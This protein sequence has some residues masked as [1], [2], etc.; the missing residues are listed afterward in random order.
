MEP[1][2]NLKDEL[3]WIAIRMAISD[4]SL[5]TDILILH[6]QCTALSVCSV[7]LGMKVFL[8]CGIISTGIAGAI[9]S[10]II[11]RDMYR[12]KRWLKLRG[13]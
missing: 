13:K 9:G 7:I 12:Y 8:N 1:N 3:E 5:T 4:D 10:V 2:N 6:L 11:F